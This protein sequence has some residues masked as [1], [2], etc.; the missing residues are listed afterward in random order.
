MLFD[1]TEITKRFLFGTDNPS[2]DDYNKHIRPAIGSAGSKPAPKKYSMLDYLT[3]GAGR[4]A[5]PSLFGAVEKFFQSD[6][7]KNQ[8]YTFGQ[9]SKQL[10]FANSDFRVGISQY[11]TDIFSSDHADRSYIFGGTSFKLD[12]SRAT[13][14]V[15]GSSKTIKGLEVR[16]FD[17]NFD[18]EGSNPFID[19]INVGLEA[20]IDPYGLAREQLDI[21][22]TGNGKVYAAYTQD[23]F[24]KNNKDNILD[25]FSDEQKVS[26]TGTFSQIGKDT[27]GLALLGAKGP[28][29]LA[30]LHK[31]P[32]LDFER[33]KFT[34]I[35]GTP[36][37]DSLDRFDGAN[38]IDTPFE[39]YLF[40]GGAGDD[41][42]TGSLSDDEFQGGS[43]NDTLDGGEGK[44]DVAVYSG[45]IDEYDFSL[46]DDL[47]TIT[48]DHVGGSGADGRDTL[49]NIEFGQFAGKQ[50]SLAGA[51]IVFVIDSTGSMS[52]DIAQV[53]AQTTQIID[54][55][56]EKVPLARF[57]VVTYKDPGET[58]TN[59][60]FTT[61]PNV[62]RAA[63]NSISVFGGG[64]FPEGVNS[65]LLH[66]LREEQGLGDWRP[67]ATPRSIILIGDAPAKDTGLRSQVINEAKKRSVEFD[68]RITPEPFAARSF[69]A[70]AAERGLTDASAKISVPTPLA[71]EAPVFSA[72]ETVE[73]LPAFPV[74]IFPVI[75]G[76][77]FST[78]AD[79]TEVAT[80]TGGKTF[81]AATANEV[82][83]AV[84]AAL[85]E[86]V[87]TPGDNVVGTNGTDTLVGTDADDT[88]TGSGGRDTLTG[89]A[90]KDQFIYT[91][92]IDA[93]DTITDF[94]VGS[95]LL[96]FTEL[97]KSIGFE[98]LDPIASGVVGFVGRG[99]NTI[100]TLDPDGLAGRARARSFVS[101]EGVSV[102]ALN[103]AD[104][105][106]FS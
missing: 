2:S 106:V 1:P 53:K 5:Y 88:I 59:G 71:A 90:G 102:S 33:G 6:S 14:E 82:V 91:S 61:D 41:T 51:D 44:K 9:L 64:D 26:V 40:V 43:G 16:A 85:D 37:D 57:A 8:T 29:F 35:Y 56:A 11:G 99:D 15:S 19:L 24:A 52:D 48:I 103:N 65:G 78:I 36:G 21:E 76:S 70:V 83:G 7:L 84:I 28:F 89:G 42:M 50:V 13:F 101:V 27:D 54:D 49:K 75:I 67:E 10:S 12:L 3:E 34:V 62:A 47:K 38:F 4:Y 104:N 72:L 55:T 63:I 95:D 97:F 60:A 77:D 32:F 86:A 45:N 30:D 87:K 79:F 25:I 23:E 18:F 105:F 94:E 98:G 17:D 80:A 20:A 58:I 73:T 69:L 100:I 74:K 39:S 31:D 22:F 68:E 66:A 81:T 96:V 46:S 93:G 92:P